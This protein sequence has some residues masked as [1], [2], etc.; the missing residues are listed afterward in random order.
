MAKAPR[1]A[2]RLTLLFAAA[3]LVVLLARLPL[4][5]VASLLP[6]SL[7]CESPEG[8]LWAGRCGSLSVRTPSGGFLLVGETDWTLHPL[9][10]L[11]AHLSLDLQVRRGL[12]H[13]AGRVHLGFGGMNVS[14]LNAQGP[15]DPALLPG[16]PPT[17]SGRLEVSDL[18]LALSGG[19]LVAL[20]GT[21]IARDLTQQ[22]PQRLP[23]GSY[24]VTFPAGSGPALAPGRVNDLGGPLQLQAT[25]T[26]QPTLQ[27]SLDGEVAAR[28]NGDPVIAQWLQS[29]PL[30]ADARGQRHF[31]FA[32][33]SFVNP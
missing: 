5:W 23:F 1:T 29:L 21:A 26:L 18:Q 16:F 28:P 3:L 8:S 30:A 11:T 20:Q 2:L 33:P 25:V 27:W 19:K 24:Q 4:R 31:S 15:M 7:H 9:A 13:A 12:S 6:A 10:L 22:L 17:W 14:H 32:S